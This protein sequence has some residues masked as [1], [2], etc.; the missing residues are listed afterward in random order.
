MADRMCSV[1]GEQVAESVRFCPTC[2]EPIPDL[3]DL[4]EPIRSIP[5]GGLAAVMP[6]WLRESAPVA[7]APAAPAPAVVAPVT[8]PQPAT[9]IAE[10]DVPAW[11]RTYAA[12]AESASSSQP[13]PEAIPARPRIEPVILPPAPS[14]AV[15]ASTPE[16]Q[17]VIAPLPESTPV[18]SPP[19][20]HASPAADWTILA[21]VLVAIVVAVAVVLVLA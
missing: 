21:I 5:D 15:T 1:C 19:T 20:D 6:A 9:L 11:M 8:D 10:D 4:P 17:P 14:P 12:R 18:V 3:V 16:P 7:P 13:T 2:G